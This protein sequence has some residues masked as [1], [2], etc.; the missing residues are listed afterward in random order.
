MPDTLRRACG[1]GVRAVPGCAGRAAKQVAR[2]EIAP[3]EASRDVRRAAADR[4]ARA[5]DADAVPTPAGAVRWYPSTVRRI[6]AAERTREA[7]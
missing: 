6:L 3:F 7:A 5:L 2:V 1:L 4:I